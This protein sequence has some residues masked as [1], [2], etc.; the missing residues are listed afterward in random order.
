MSESSEISELLLI[1]EIPVVRPIILVDPAVFTISTETKDL[2]CIIKV[3]SPAMSLL[4]GGNG[5]LK[6][7]F[8]VKGI[9]IGYTQKWR[10]SS[11]CM[12]GLVSI[13]FTRSVSGDRNTT[14]RLKNK[15]GARKKRRES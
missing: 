8:R 6:N 14:R 7:K 5:R 1:R 2:A 13:D 9:L 11:T 10:D 15:M 3:E 12:R 4:G